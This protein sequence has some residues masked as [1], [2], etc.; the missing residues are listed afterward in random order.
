MPQLKL[1]SQDE[2]EGSIPL[3]MTALFRETMITLIFLKSRFHEDLCFLLVDDHM[4]QAE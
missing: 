1:Y 4:T 3:T 2:L